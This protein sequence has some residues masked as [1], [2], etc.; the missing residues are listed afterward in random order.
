VDIFPV[1][2]RMDDA[3]VAVFGGGETARRKVR[4]LA[5]T[6]AVI[7]VFADTLDGPFRG[8]FGEAVNWHPLR[9]AAKILRD[10]RFAIIAEEGEGAALAAF[11]LARASGVPVNSVD[12]KAWCDFTVPSIMDRGRVVGAI[13]TGGAAPVLAKQLRAA[14]EEATPPGVAALSAWAAGLRAAVRLHATARRRAGG[15]GR[16]FLPARRRSAS[17]RAIQPGRPRRLTL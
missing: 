11:Q 12:R 3:A 2:F 5:K 6:P 17:W 1:F 14:M 8:E 15:C 13:A 10:C 9:T 7:H 16:A 4:L